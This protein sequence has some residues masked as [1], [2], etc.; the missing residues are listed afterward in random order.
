MINTII[1]IQATG[2]YL[3][4]SP[5]KTRRILD[6]I[7]GKSYQEAALILEF[8]PYKP[9]KIIKKIL[10]S[11]G[12]NASNLKYEKQDLIVQQAFTNEGPKLKRFQPRAQ[13]RAFKIQKPTCHITIKLAL[14]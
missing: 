11:A 10:E 2:K 12:N 9:C 8:M 3:R 4:V 13:G 1:Q 7:R 5:H 6:Q 14:K